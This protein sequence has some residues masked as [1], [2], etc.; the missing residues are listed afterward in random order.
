MKNRFLSCVHKIYTHVKQE[1]KLDNSVSI[2]VYS[3]E[4]FTIAPVSD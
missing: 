4:R 2:K 1:N 3:E